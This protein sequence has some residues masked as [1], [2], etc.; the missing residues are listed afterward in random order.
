MAHRALRKAVK[1]MDGREPRTALAE[2]VM[3]FLGITTAE[4]LVE[5]LREA[6]LSTPQLATLCPRV[7]G[8]A[9]YGDLGAAPI[10][11]QAYAALAHMAA[12]AARQT[13]LSAPDVILTGGLATSSDFRPGLEAA[14]R[15]AIRGLRLQEPQVPPV[16]GALLLALNALGV[17][18]S[19]P[20]ME[21]IRASL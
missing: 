11:G 5:A 3:D 10:V 21:N 7:V 4:H 13:D 16:G 19:G 2:V 1:Q 8:L 9:R 12:T 15:A 14:L 20:L 18:R 17:T 6:D